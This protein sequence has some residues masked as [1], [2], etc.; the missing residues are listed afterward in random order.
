MPSLAGWWLGC[1]S[2]TLFQFLLLR[3]YF[4]LFIWARFL[5]QVSR[6]ELKIVPTHP[7]FFGII[8]IIAGIVML[9]YPFDSIVTLALVA[10]SWLIII[11]VI[12]IVSAFGIRK[13]GNTV[14]NALTGADR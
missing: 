14:K 7:I 12:E 8:T 13:A 11:G 2:I 10:G 1:V 5:W 6:I 3:W 4:R 9:A